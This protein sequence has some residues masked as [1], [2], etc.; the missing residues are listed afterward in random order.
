MSYRSR[1]EEGR[2]LADSI[3]GRGCDVCGES[4][5][6]VLD[7]HHRNPAEKLFNLSGANLGKSKEKLDAEFAKCVVLCANCHRRVH[8]GTVELPD[9]GAGNAKSTNDAWHDLGWTDIL[10]QWSDSTGPM[11]RTG[12]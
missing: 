5:P 4:D 7:F 6:D 2:R 10:D 12:G 9:E 1:F 11:D 8:A 3:K